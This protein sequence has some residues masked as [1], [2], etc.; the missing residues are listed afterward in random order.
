MQIFVQ[1]V[2][3]K[4]ISLEVEPLATVK[5]V[6]AMIRDK[7][8]IPPGQQCIQTFVGKSNV[9]LEDGHA[10]ADYNINDRS[11]LLLSLHIGAHIYVVTPMGN[12]HT[13]LVDVS[14]TV[15]T[16]K[17]KIQGV[18][19]ITPDQQRIL[20]FSVGRPSVEVEDG[21]TLADYNIVHE[22][23][24]YLML[25]RHVGTHIYVLTPTG[26]VIIVNVK[27]SDNIAS[28]KAQI[29]DKEGFAPELQCLIFAG[30][31]LEDKVTVHDMGTESILQLVL[32]C[33][34]VLV[35]TLTGKTIRVQVECN[36]R[37]DD[38]KAKIQ[39]MEGISPNDYCCKYAGK[40]IEDGL[41][42]GLLAGH[43]TEDECIH[44]VS[45]PSDDG[46]VIF[47]KT[48]TGKVITLSVNPG[49]T[50]R[51]VKAKLQSTEGTPEHLQDLTFTGKQLQ[52]RYTLSDYRIFTG[53]T[54]YLGVHQCS[55][56]VYL[57]T[58]AG[59]II[60]MLFTDPSDSIR[61]IKSKLA[62]AEGIPTEQQ[63]LMF[64]GKELRDDFTLADCGFRLG[65][66]QPIVLSSFQIYVKP[67][68]I[69]FPRAVISMEVVAIDTAWTVKSKIHDMTGIPPRQQCLEFHGKQ[70]IDMYTLTD[71]G[72]TNDCTLCL[73]LYD[74]QICLN[75]PE[76]KT[77]TLKVDPFGGIESVMAKI[78][79]KAQNRK[80]QQCLMFAGKEIKHG[81][82]LAE[83]GI[84]DRSILDV[85]THSTCISVK[86]PTGNTTALTVEAG[87][88]V[89]DVKCKIQEQL[90]FSPHQQYLVYKG[91][92][93]QDKDAFYICNA[94]DGALIQLVLRNVIFVKT[95]LG[96]S[97]AVPYHSGAT[98]AGVKSVVE[99]EVGIPAKE[100]HL[101]LANIE[102]QD[103][104][105]VEGYVGRCLY[106]M[107]DTPSFYSQ[108][109]Q[110]EAICM[111]QY[112]KAVQDNPVVSLKL[113][114]CIVSGPP[115]VGKTWLKHVLLGQRP[116]ENSPS[117]P[118]CTKAD[119]IAVNDRIHLCGSKWTVVSNE[120]GVW[121]LLQSPQEV[122]KSTA[123]TSMA[124]H[125]DSSHPLQPHEDILSTQRHGDIQLQQS[126]G[127]SSQGQAQKES[128]SAQAHEERPSAQAH[129]ERLS[130]QAH[131]ERP[132]AQ[133]HE[134][135]LSALAHEERPSALAHE[136]RLSAQAHEERPSAQAH[137]ERPSA[138]AHEERPSAL[139]HEERPLAQAH[140]ERPL[141][142]AHEERLSALAH[143]ERP[144]AQAHEERLSAQAHEEKPSTQAH[145]ERLS[146]QAHEERLSAQAHEERLSAQA[147]EE[148]LSTQA[149]EEKPSA[150]AHE[151]RLSAQAHEER[152][153]AQAHEERP[154]AQAHEERLS[155][156]A[157]EERPSAQAHE[158]R[159]S[160][161]AHEEKPSTQAH[162][163]RLSAQAH[164]ERL[165]AQAH[166]ERLSAQAHE[167]R[168]STQAHEEKPSAQAHEE[169]LSAQAHEERLSA[170]A[171][172]ER[173]S[174]QAHEERLSAQ[175]HE[176]K[177]STQAHEERLS[178]QAHEER[179]SAQAHEE[180]LSAQAHEERLS[181]QAHEEKPS[182][183][184]HE[185]KLSTQAH[186]ERLS[187]Q[188][189]EDSPLPQAPKE[190]SPTQLQK[191]RL[192]MEA[193]QETPSAP[194]KEMSIKYTHGMDLSM[195]TSAN[196][197]HSDSKTVS[198]KDFNREDMVFPHSV[199][200][201]DDTGILTDAFSNGLQIPQGI[202]LSQS[203]GKA[204]ITEESIQDQVSSLA[205]MD[206]KAF[207]AQASVESI[208]QTTL[209][210]P[211]L[212]TQH[213]TGTPKGVKAV[214]ELTSGVLKDREKLEYIAF[215]DSMFLQFIDTGGQ[216]SFH[217][218]LP[219]FTN[220]RS[221][222]VHLQVF[223]LCE[224][225]EA[226]PKDQLRLASHGTMYSSQSSFTNLEM[227]VRS[228]T[229]IHSM[230]DKP[231]LILSEDNHQPFLRL[232]LVGTHKDKLRAE[233]EQ[234]NPH[235][236]L[237]DVVSNI[238]RVLE[239]ALTS[240]PFFHDVVRNWACGDQEMILFPMD[241]SQYLHSTIPE[242]DIQLLQN[243]RGM[244]AEACKV[245]N[246]KHETPV[247]WMLCQMLLDSQSKEKPFYVYSDLLSQCLSQGFV[248]DD[249][250]CI[251]MVQ[252][253]HDLGLFFHHHSGLPNEVDHLRG[254]DSHCTCLVFTDPSFLYF[255]IS[256][257][258]HVQFQ[259][260]PVGPLRRL[261]LDGVLTTTVLADPE[262]AIDEKLDKHWLLHLLL[263]LGITAKLPDKASR[264]SLEEYF[265]P[266]VLHPS[267]RSMPPQRTCCQEPL[268]VSFANKNYIPC[269]VFP[270]A[271]TYILASNPKWRI[272]TKFTCGKFIYFA[273]GVNYIELIE[274]NSFIRIVFSSD[275][276]SIDEQ[277]FFFYRNA[278]LTSIAQSYRKLYKVE[279]ITGILT[280]GVLCP[281]ADHASTDSHFALLELSGKEPYAQC[282]E[283]MQ[284][285]PLNS[286]QK[287]LFHSLTHA[288]SHTVELHKNVFVTFS[289]QI[290]IMHAQ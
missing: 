287:L 240:K 46:M 142:Q 209:E 193:Y 152:L 13:L 8:G 18:A 285:R 31:I 50:L 234:V 198:H 82:T 268:I 94:S 223:N 233:C 185:E 180:R 16:V 253:F 41:V 196:T 117:T 78:Q 55:N 45:H 20:Y 173:L 222:T 176:E 38:L 219:I 119:M 120:S 135:R 283:S 247:T 147:H 177:P 211:E 270:A 129:E 158:E 190:S 87:D 4:I 273:C 279:D 179:L 61:S 62:H 243:L 134:E 217:D 269:G 113:A 168:L 63:H 208:H 11:T 25:R 236:E 37:I 156:L 122:P 286:E 189:H 212:K 262:L 80:E 264:W 290:R 71:Y 266:S 254:D 60:T 244:I 114:K 40:E 9:Q 124:V 181:A 68:M 276:H 148:R 171:H 95:I 250:E 90:G 44:L 141:A 163:E 77:I 274:T 232:I 164:E 175:A 241:N 172:E 32:C 221:P 53:I 121:S 131:E 128:P 224:S 182:T 165:S 30:Y 167:E 106:L 6:K 3:G 99:C 12:I 210:F 246:A 89:K 199:K 139:A 267:D 42:L 245:P 47:V 132:L 289:L 2:T 203:E 56:A 275:L 98:I 36:D 278:V 138:L 280:V 136:E 145:E 206:K 64:A 237:D 73:S 19:G 15:E 43:H 265:L 49:D 83:Y 79:E 86:T 272:V 93:L 194:S 96:K 10:L 39:G 216:L 257:L 5:N 1:T 133:A 48:L 150:Q 220:Q 260:T 76:G 205:Q 69:N 281:F 66:T 27:S 178:A 21:Y 277:I 255:N 226:R 111:A 35:K 57:T 197:A 170:Q 238:D 242:E 227:I 91:Y 174:A 154:L 108:T 110:L 204:T 143:E 258:F 92:L 256:K 213:S 26:K 284:A 109:Q 192:S 263:E 259:R 88:T 229:S 107:S 271:I 186:E 248:K 112:Q 161:Q 51:A 183:Q 228:L 218:I 24:L 70:L 137:E 105:S 149:H 123:G 116:P 288:V 101:F 23:T 146:A 225:L 153:S 59:K 85:V 115:G 230:A 118:V 157:H 65:C 169:R 166:E 251:A 261:K 160:A 102:L 28:V 200:Q 67:Q 75:L 130:A 144:S 127:V 126:E 231:P 159:L 151:E 162:E 188:A 103:S 22:S 195:T 207:S 104:V 58:P 100:Q 239:E 7:E 187:A 14:D 72:I 33:K 191:E 202:S 282:L 54:L 17:V 235:K 34:S 81:H 155:A 140:E 214:A 252:F 97:I 215:H 125:S 29:A 52:N 184:A 84:W 74:M 249:E 201:H